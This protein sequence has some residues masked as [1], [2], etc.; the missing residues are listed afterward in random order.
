MFVTGTLKAQFHRPT[1]FLSVEN[2]LKLS[3]PS[4]E[5]PTKIS[6]EESLRDPESPDDLCPSRACKNICR[7]KFLIWVHEIAGTSLRVAQGREGNKR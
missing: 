3:R 4:L 6:E 7:Y 1:L 5:E 2:C